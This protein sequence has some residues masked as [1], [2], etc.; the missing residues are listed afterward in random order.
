V[1]ELSACRRQD[2]D[3]SR[4]PS[5]SAYPWITLVIV[6]PPPSVFRAALAA[7]FVSRHLS[8]AI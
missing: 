4:F 8:S 3:V 1:L 2:L 7:I 6:A 5:L